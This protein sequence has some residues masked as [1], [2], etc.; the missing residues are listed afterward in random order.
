MPHA[1]PAAAGAWHKPRRIHFG[2]HQGVGVGVAGVAGV[3]AWLAQEQ[4]V[5]VV[6]RHACG[7]LAMALRQAASRRMADALHEPGLQRRLD[8]TLKDLDREC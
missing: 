5:E 2:P 7:A 1:W 8:K 4:G 6:L 3:A